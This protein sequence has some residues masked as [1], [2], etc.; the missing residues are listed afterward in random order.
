MKEGCF[1]AS[2][3]EKESNKTH[4]LDAN[5]LETQPPF[6][7]EQHLRHF[8][9]VS[10]RSVIRNDQDHRVRLRESN[11]IKNGAISSQ[12]RRRKE[13]RREKHVEENE[14]KH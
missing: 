1:E 2:Q 8:L 4:L 5:L 12:S 10:L 11:E 6:F 7:S 3:I 13:E 14:T 9:N